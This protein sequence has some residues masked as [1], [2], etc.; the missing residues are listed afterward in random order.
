MKMREAT[1]MNENDNNH[2]NICFQ[3]TIDDK[4][5]QT[6]SIAMSKMEYEQYDSLWIAACY[7]LMWSQIQILIGMKLNF[8]FLEENLSPMW[9]K[10]SKDLSPGCFTCTSVICGVA[11]DHATNVAYYAKF[12]V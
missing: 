11:N 4:R 9:D 7:F 1:K 8:E 10:S 6:Q 3:D 5:R 12:V 2:I